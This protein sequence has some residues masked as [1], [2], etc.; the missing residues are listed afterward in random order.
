MLWA[1]LHFPDFSLQLLLR[2]AP[3]AG[4]LAVTT[5]ER[6]PRILSCNALARAGGIRPGMRVSAAFALVPEL[7][8]RPRDMAAEQA[9][10][11]GL[12]AWAGQYTSHASLAPPDALLLEL[13]GSLRLFGG[14]DALL[15]HLDSQVQALGYQACIAAA[16]TPGAARLL[17]RAGQAVRI[18]Q[19]A[20][21]RQAL[22][23]LPVDLLE[24][25]ESTLQAL[26]AA[27]IDTLGQCLELPRAGLA[28]RF[29]PWLRE[30]IDRALGELPD[31]QPVF[32]APESYHGRIQLPAPVGS[33]EP[34]LFVA[35]RLLGEL[36]G[37]LSVRR[38][39]AV[40]LVLE[41]H[42]E[43]GG[44]RP[45]TLALS[46]PSRDPLHLQ[47][48]LHERLGTLRLDERVDSLALHCPLSCSQDPGQGQGSLLPGDP[49]SRQAS[50]RI[51][52]ELRARLGHEAVRGIAVVADHRPERAW[53]L[54][55]PGNAGPVVTGRR[56]LWLLCPP[57]R[58]DHT[59]GRPLFDGPLDLEGGAERIESGWWD[60]A[61]VRRDYFL[62]RN[63][64]EELLWIFREHRPPHDWYLQ[65]VFG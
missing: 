64:R 18:G 28:R 24:A 7:A 5:R 32:R 2:A 8:E 49:A 14:L 19:G 16:P 59:D 42:L 39:A 52:D 27:G 46:A 35:R 40:T 31:P 37:F 9:A 56:P 63:A 61:D 54:C 15:V 17:A 45:L 21:L 6:P 25:P 11:H 1:C 43:D 50:A 33:V 58:L 38:S 26:G 12:A 4:A 57:R 36:C 34:L 23:T 29:G 20:Q 41:L 48:L 44:V 47:V 13:Q 3:Q 10:L 22:A 53:R 60:G 55:D 51:I 65:G 62:A 30:A